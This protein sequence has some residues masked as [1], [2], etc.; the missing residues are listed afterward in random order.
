MISIR[1]SKKIRSKKGLFYIETE[2]KLLR[3]SGTW[4]RKVLDICFHRLKKNSDTLG[5]LIPLEMGV[6]TDKTNSN[7]EIKNRNVKLFQ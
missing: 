2:K 1:S 5:N 6:T 3:N 4:Q 7:E